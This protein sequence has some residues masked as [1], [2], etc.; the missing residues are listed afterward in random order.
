MTT[1]A[2]YQVG[3]PFSFTEEEEQE[4]AMLLRQAQRALWVRT[5]GYRGAV[6]DCVTRVNRII[7]GAMNRSH[8]VQDGSGILQAPLPVIRPP[9]AD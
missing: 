3:R 9:F 2:Q 4:I 8:G 6:I 1:P 5:A 7:H